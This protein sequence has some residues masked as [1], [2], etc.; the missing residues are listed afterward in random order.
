MSSSNQSTNPVSRAQ[1]LVAAAGPGCIYPS[2]TFTSNHLTTLNAHVAAHFESRTPLNDALLADYL[3]RTSAHFNNAVAHAN[4]T[5]YPAA[6]NSH[7]RILPAAATGPPTAHSAAAPAAVAR[8]HC[9]HPSCTKTFTRATDRDRHAR[10]HDPTA[11]TWICPA[12]GC[13][14]SFYRKDK[15]DA[16]VGMRHVGR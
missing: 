15:R 6:V 14:Q 13:G 3:S 16:H 11:Q 9:P 8:Y 1:S 12:A 7:T 4:S 10:K 2:C 5:S